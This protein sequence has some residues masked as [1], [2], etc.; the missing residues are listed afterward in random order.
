MN[1]SMDEWLKKTLTDSEYQVPKSYEKK[2]DQTIKEIQNSKVIH[3]AG[4]FSRFA[5]NKAAGAVLIVFLLSAVSISSFAAVN[6][7]RDRMSSMSEIERQNYN[8]DIQNC[9]VDEDVLSRELTLEEREQIAVL[10]E[11]YEKEGKFPQKEI[12]QMKTNEGTV[13]DELYFVADESKFYLPDR[14]MTEEEMLQMIDLQEKRDYSVRQQNEAEISEDQKGQGA[15][16]QDAWLERR[17]VETVAKLYELAEPELEIVSNSVKDHCYEVAQK[18]GGSRFFVYYT[19]DHAIERV[20]YKKKDVSAHQSGVQSESLHIKRISKKMK[21]RAEVFTGKEMDTQSSYGM[22]EDSGELAHGTISFYHQMMDGSVC[23]AVYST[24]YD[25][26]Y[27]MYKLDDMK[28]ARQQ[29]R[30]KKR[31]VGERGVRYQEIK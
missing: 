31:A 23:V 22:M 21:K 12:R 10:R 26:L 8:S 20:V 13:A 28:E 17:S 3:R 1:R 30:D 15:G 25:D 2:L 29:I 4:R 11:Q 27:D 19:K 6:L 9:K 16:G 18:E 7:F 24:A 5:V 14:A